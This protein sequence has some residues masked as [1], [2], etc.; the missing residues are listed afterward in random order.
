MPLIATG[1]V[2]DHLMF[3]ILLLVASGLLEY[4]AN[5]RHAAATMGLYHLVCVTAWAWLQTQRA[6]NLGF[7]LLTVL[8]FIAIEFLIARLKGD[9]QQ[10]TPE[11]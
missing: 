8:I 11:T 6:F 7:A 9:S 2:F 10:E 4:N 3:S 5:G 1:M